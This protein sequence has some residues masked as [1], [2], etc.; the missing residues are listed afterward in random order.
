MRIDMLANT[1]ASFAWLVRAEPLDVLGTELFLWRTKRDHAIE[2]SRR[3]ENSS[4]EGCRFLRVG[5]P[6]R[7]SVG[8]P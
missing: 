7:K 8:R 2:R 5:Q 1:A 3:F 4:I 6:G